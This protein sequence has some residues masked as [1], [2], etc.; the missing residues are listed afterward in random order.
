MIGYSLFQCDSLGVHGVSDR[1][2]TLMYAMGLP[3]APVITEQYIRA[4]EMAESMPV[5]PLEGSILPEG[6]Y[7]RHKAVRS[8]AA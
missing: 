4:V 1:A 7:G 8:R 6:G 2:G 3:H 5:W